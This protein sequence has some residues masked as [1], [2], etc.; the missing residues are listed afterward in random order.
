MRPRLF[1]SVRPG[2]PPLPPRL[3]R[4]SHHQVFREPIA[5]QLCALAVIL[6]ID[7]VMSSGKNLVLHERR[8]GYRTFGRQAGVF[9]AP[10]FFVLL[11]NDQCRH[12]DVRGGGPRTI[13]PH[14]REISD[15]SKRLRLVFG[16]RNRKQLSARDR[17]CEVL[18]L[19]NRSHESVPVRHGSH[20]WN[21]AYDGL[22]SRI[23]SCDT[24]D[25]AAAE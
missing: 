14:R 17:T 5:R 8:V 22:N 6:L 7:V 21:L 12:S 13:T 15:P 9:A 19:R 1:V 10:V 4:T 11:I 23:S 2:V 24:Q 20:S 18:Y 16:A 25:M 3:S